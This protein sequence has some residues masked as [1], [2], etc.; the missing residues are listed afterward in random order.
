MLECESM[1]EDNTSALMVLRGDYESILGNIEWNLAGLVSAA[2]IIINP[3]LLHLQTVPL[4]II[5]DGLDL[6]GFQC[7]GLALIEK[8]RQA[9]ANE[10]L[11]AAKRSLICESLEVCADFLARAA[12]IAS[13][14]RDP[15]AHE[16]YF[17]VDIKELWN[18]KRGRAGSLLEES[19]REF[20]EKFVALLRNFI[21]HNNG[22][23]PPRRSIVYAGK[24]KSKQFNFSLVW[25][26]DG[27]ND[28][29]APLN[30]AHDI[31]VTLRDISLAGFRRA[32]LD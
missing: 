23:L 18:A 1:A 19:D 24:P 25:S 28:I 30:I 31:F 5:L 7:L 10:L 9:R 2:M 26:S 14:E 6:D 15:Y 3:K 32:T 22:K 27:T 4:R 16:D 20:I 17:S 29:S 11:A 8:D 12:R 13:G 21:R